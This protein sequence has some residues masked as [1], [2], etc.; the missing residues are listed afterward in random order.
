MN[1]NEVKEY[2]E[3]LAL[4]TGSEVE[5]ATFWPAINT[6]VEQ[7]NK[8]RPIKKILEIYNFCMP[9]STIT[10]SHEDNGNMVIA[11]EKCACFILRISGECKIDT[12]FANEI[13]TSYSFYDSGQINEY[14]IVSS[15]LGKGEKPDIELVISG[16]KIYHL[17]EYEFYSEKVSN[18]ID[19]IPPPGKYNLYDLSKICSEYLYCDSVLYCDNEYSVRKLKETIDYVISGDFLWLPKNNPGTYRIQYCSKVPYISENNKNEALPL[20]PALHYI[21]PLLVCY[22]VW[23]E[24]KPEIAQAMYAQYLKSAMDLQNESRVPGFPAVQD[25]YNGW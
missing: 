9:R 5:M 3:R 16:D 25:A 24:D 7:I 23:L 10:I 14:R 18:D 22:Y 2:A 4:G 6:A 21:V 13:L 12:Y 8:I 11:A 20:D 19:D 15:T 1:A 17:V